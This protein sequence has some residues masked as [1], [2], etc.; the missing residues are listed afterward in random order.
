MGGKGE[1]GYLENARGYFKR[2]RA[3]NDSEGAMLA[4]QSSALAS[5]VGFSGLRSLSLSGQ[6]KSKN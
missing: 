2:T 3:S 1:E 6:V 5:K 4:N